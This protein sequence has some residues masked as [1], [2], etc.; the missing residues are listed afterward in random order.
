M[1]LLWKQVVL[2]FVLMLVPT[3]LCACPHESC[4]QTEM[5]ADGSNF[6]QIDLQEL[7]HRLF[8]E[9]G[10]AASPEDQEPSSSSSEVRS[11][12]SAV[13][14]DASQTLGSFGGLDLRRRLSLLA[15]EL[16]ARALGQAPPRE[17]V[18]QGRLP[19]DREPIANELGLTE[20][21]SASSLSSS[22]QAS[23]TLMDADELNAR[24]AE[25]L[26]KT[27]L[28]HVQHQLR[29]AEVAELKKASEEEAMAESLEETA[30]RVRASQKSAANEMS[31]TSRMFDFLKDA[32][33][34]AQDV[35]VLQQS[36]EK[37]EEKARIH[38]E[39]A[40]QQ[41]HAA[42]NAA[43]NSEEGRMLEEV[44]KETLRAQAEVVSSSAQQEQATYSFNSAL[45]NAAQAATA[46]EALSMRD[47]ELALQNLSDNMK[48]LQSR[49]LR[50]ATAD[51]EVAQL[52]KG[53][54]QDVVQANQA[55]QKMHQS[56][57]DSNREKDLTVREMAAE[58]HTMAE[59]SRKIAKKGQHVASLLNKAKELI[60]EDERRAALEIQSA[61]DLKA[62]AMNMLQVSRQKQEWIDKQIHDKVQSLTTAGQQVADAAD[63]L[64]F[65]INPEPHQG[66]ALGAL[67]TDGRDTVRASLDDVSL[68]SAELKNGVGLFG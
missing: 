3:P 56:F 42:A 20:K 36:L 7:R 35:H 23:K 29:V 49:A 40:L 55:A 64:R 9:S 15:S 68:K 5:E 31:Y 46:S 34:Q 13:N 12:G 11:S 16:S 37:R 53:T 1:S 57:E 21:E 60:V 58:K 8:D 27:R 33:K 47:T 26:L 4:E 32:A 50:S 22:S 24:S 39:T 44:L 14:E 67:Q 18:M 62:Q 66:E 2:C 30:N 43:G 38:L 25:A 17:S 19:S 45:H 41:V 28:N 52:M 59:E 10:P 51:T 6:L 61:N 63:S 54:A 48:L 65:N